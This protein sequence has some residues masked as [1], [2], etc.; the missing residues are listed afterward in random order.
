M[1]GAVLILMVLALIACAGWCQFHGG[2]WLGATGR[3][4][5]QGMPRR[6]L[7]TGFWRGTGYLLL[8]LAL[9]TVAGFVMGRAL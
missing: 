7:R 2:T 8:A 9:S 3:L 6:M 1:S 4:Q 5:A